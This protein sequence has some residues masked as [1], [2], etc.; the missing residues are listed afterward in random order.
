MYLTKHTWDSDNNN[1]FRHC[2]DITNGRNI[3]LLGYDFHSESGDSEEK[4]ILSEFLGST[5]GPTGFTL[6]GAL[7]LVFPI[8]YNN[9]Y[10]KSLNLIAN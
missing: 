1:S 4:H 2:S 9:D 3:D 7:H 8:L 10:I 6:T 5:G